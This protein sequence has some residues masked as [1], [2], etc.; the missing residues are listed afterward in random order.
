MGE[1]FNL[2]DFVLIWDEAWLMWVTVSA[3]GDVG[4]LDTVVMASS[5]IQRAGFI[6]DFIVVHEL[7][8]VNWLST[9]ASIIFH[10]AR[11]QNLRSDVDIGPSCLSCNL[12]SI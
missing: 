8:S 9:V 5:L 1:L 7:V 10:L 6:S 12:D 11:D 2:I 4:A 3:H